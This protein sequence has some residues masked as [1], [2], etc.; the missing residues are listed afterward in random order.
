MICC[1]HCRSTP[2]PPPSVN[3]RA[4]SVESAEESSYIVKLNYRSSWSNFDTSSRVVN[5]MRA[6]CLPGYPREGGCLPGYPG[7]VVLCLGILERG[8]SAGYPGEGVFCWVPWRGGC[9]PGYR[10][11]RVLCLGILERG[12]VCLGIQER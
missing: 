4:R 5:P 9:L 6:G 11:E 3:T 7:E 10:G 1:S 12:V 2:S 8:L